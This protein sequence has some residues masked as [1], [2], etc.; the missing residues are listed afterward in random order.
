M[1][2]V[3]DCADR[4]HLQLPLLWYVGPKLTDRLVLSACGH[5]IALDLQPSRYET[6]QVSC[7]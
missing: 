7:R 5:W 1:L 3:S 6:M 4:A 2:E